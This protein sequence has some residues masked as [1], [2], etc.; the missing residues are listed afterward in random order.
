MVR[1]LTKANN[2]RHYR[3]MGTLFGNVVHNS[4]WR[5]RRALALFW[6]LVAILKTYKC[7]CNSGTHALGWYCFKNEYGSWF[8]IC[9]FF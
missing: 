8:E 9:L 4:Y 1:V 2:L 6:H 7:Y 3:Y 5:C